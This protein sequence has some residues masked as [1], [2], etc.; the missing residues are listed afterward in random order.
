MTARR[1][2]HGAVSRLGYGGFGLAGVFESVE[3]DEAVASVRYALERGIDVIDVARAY[4]PAE[5]IAGE[6]LRHWSGPRPV[7]ATKVLSTGP[8][9]RWGI[10]PSVDEVFPPG[11]VTESTH[12]SLR[13]LGVDH[14]DLQ[15]LH[16]YWPNWGVE[17]YWLDELQALR[18]AGTIGAI[19]VSLPDQRHDVGLP[20]VQSG[21]IDSVQT[22]VNIFD[23]TA[24][25]CLVP[26]CAERG[27]AVIARC[28]LDE[29]GLTGMLSTDTVFPDGDYR[30]G[31]FDQGPREQYLARVEALRSYVPE[32]AS[33]LAALALKFVL[34]QEA[35]TTSVVTMHL[36]RFAQLNI[37]VLDETPLD[38]TVAEELRRRHRWVR[39]FYNRKVM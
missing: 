37:D 22:V 1:F 5:A 6:A 30:A 13:Q 8:L 14:L 17:G 27:V 39:N 35:V 24:L 11:R 28:V 12:E 21:A 16:L 15:Q 31:Y 34:A 36:R 32:H 23:P 3:R 33:S 20:L 9:S 38:P 7:L 10:P 25:D 19:G 18:D 26:A 2:R 4:G 29:G